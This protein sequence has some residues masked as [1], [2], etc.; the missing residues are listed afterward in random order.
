MKSMLDLLAGVQKCEEYEA[1]NRQNRRNDYARA[2]PPSTA[3]Q[4]APDGGNNRANGTGRQ[5]Y[6]GN[7][8]GNVPVKAAL[9]E[10]EY[11]GSGGGEYDVG[12]LGEPMYDENCEV[13]LGYR[14]AVDYT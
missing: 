6:P 14:T 3:R 11:E 1:S 12:D 10:P 4:N 2:Y 7:A 5:S 13:P 9:V 8:R